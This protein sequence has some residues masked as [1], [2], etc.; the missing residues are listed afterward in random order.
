MREVIGIDLYNHL[1]YGS[2]SMTLTG[3]R[4]DQHHTNCLL[5]INS[6]GGVW[7]EHLTQAITKDKAKDME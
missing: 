6:S 5:I 4:A 3:V 1:I 2:V 7:L